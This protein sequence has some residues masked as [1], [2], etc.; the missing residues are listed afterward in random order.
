MNN[1][2]PI[3]RR[4]FSGEDV[5]LLA[6][7]GLMSETGTDASRRLFEVGLRCC[8]FKPYCLILRLPIKRYSFVSEMILVIIE[9]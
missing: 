9:S 7:N 6:A 2:L 5:A 3:R 8:L 1:R 4:L